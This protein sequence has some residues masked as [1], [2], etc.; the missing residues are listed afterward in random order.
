MLSPDVSVTVVGAIEFLRAQAALEVLFA[1][2]DRVNMAFDVFF[3][4]RRVV[5][6]RILA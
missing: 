3:F 6:G 5:A 4:D 2:V 1:R